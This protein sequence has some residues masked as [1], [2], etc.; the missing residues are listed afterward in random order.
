[1]YRFCTASSWF[2][3]SANSGLYR[4]M[5]DALRAVDQRINDENC[6]SSFRALDDPLA[7]PGLKVLSGELKLSNSRQDVHTLYLSSLWRKQNGPISSKY[8]ERAGW[9]VS[10]RS[11]AAPQIGMD[12]RPLIHRMN[13]REIYPRTKAAKRSFGGSQ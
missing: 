10:G 1:M 4:A 3:H 8:L 13:K 12:E 7:W 9:I 5:R 2:F 11:G 6:L